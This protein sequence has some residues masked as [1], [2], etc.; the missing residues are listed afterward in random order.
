MIHTKYACAG[1]ENNEEA[2]EVMGMRHPEEHET[3]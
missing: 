2:Q 1:K 3:R